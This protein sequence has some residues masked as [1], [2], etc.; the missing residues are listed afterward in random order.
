VNG[1][2]AARRRVWDP[3]VRTLHWMLVAAYA[4]AWATT[5]AFGDAHEA[6][7]YAGLAV[8]LVRVVW[9]FVGP[10]PARFVGFVRA[11]RPTL[12]YLGQ[13]VAHREPR[14]L[15]HNPLGAWMVVALLS[16]MVALAFT[17]WLYRT[18]RFWGSEEVELAHSSL[19]WLSVALVALHVGGV[20][21][22]SFRHGENLVAAMW[23][24]E[25]RAAAGDDV[26]VP[27]PPRAQ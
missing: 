6:I 19:A 2:A 22:T 8:V 14:Y 9:G 25:K 18:D 17:G 3:L 26:D 12:A 1:G 10:A 5:V 4:G 7:G 27:Q 15:G 11:P 21:Y 13:V 24:G 23:S 20:V 16:C